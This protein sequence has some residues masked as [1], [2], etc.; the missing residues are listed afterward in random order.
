MMYLVH[1]SSK[2]NG[3]VWKKRTWQYPDKSLKNDSD[4]KK[5]HQVSQMGWHSV[6]A[7]FTLK[8]SSWDI[9]TSKLSNALFNDWVLSQTWKP[10]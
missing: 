9:I 10:E 7:W 3:G 4:N 2:R 8:A 5:S 1:I 6:Q